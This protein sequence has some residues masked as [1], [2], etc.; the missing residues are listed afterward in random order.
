MWL[1][2][3]IIILKKCHFRAFTGPAPCWLAQCNQNPS[4]LLLVGFWRTTSFFFTNFNYFT[5]HVQWISGVGQMHPLTPPS[6]PLCYT[7]PSLLLNTTYHSH[8]YIFTFCWLY[9]L[10]KKLV[11][12]IPK[13]M[14][15]E[16]SVFKN[17][18]LSNR[19]LLYCIISLSKTALPSFAF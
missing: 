11:K 10:S 8:L 7:L 4:L 9:K 13:L 1:C 15:S 6:Y 12:C 3:Q 18:F 16:V 19:S 5:L 14:C 2:Q 17:N